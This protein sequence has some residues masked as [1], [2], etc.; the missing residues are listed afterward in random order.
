MG[1]AGFSPRCSG[2]ETTASQHKVTGHLC[3]SVTQRPLLVGYLPTAVAVMSRH[4]CFAHAPL[5]HTEHSQLSDSCLEA[6]VPS[7]HPCVSR[8]ACLT[9]HRSL[10]LGDG[11]ECVFRNLPSVWQPQNF[12]EVMDRKFPLDRDHTACGG[13]CERSQGERDTCT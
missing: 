1:W 4:P 12:T 11:V 5:N 7:T 9:S 2:W 8:E 13:C 3:F 6:R 10:H